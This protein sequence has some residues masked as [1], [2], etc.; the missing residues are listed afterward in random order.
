[1]HAASHCV[2]VLSR[3]T[4][5]FSA[6][7]K[8]GSWRVT[9]TGGR[10]NY[11]LV[12]SKHCRIVKPSKNKLLTLTIVVVWDVLFLRTSRAILHDGIS[13]DEEGRWLYLHERHKCKPEEKFNYQAAESWVYG[14]KI[15]HNWKLYN[16]PREA[17]NGVIRDSFYRRNGVPGL[18][19]RIKP[20]IVMVN[21][22]KWWRCRVFQGV[23]ACRINVAARTFSM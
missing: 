22:V 5:P 9:V 8:R 17:R 2:P 10:E 20:E 23:P 7:I 13:A 18:Q 21:D 3:H 14:W 12:R 4:V 6:I 11:T 19:Q 15:Q 16:R 1:M